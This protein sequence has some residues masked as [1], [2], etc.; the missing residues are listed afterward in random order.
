MFGSVPKQPMSKKYPDAYEKHRTKMAERSRSKSKESR[1]I[2]RSFPAVADKK[3][4]ARCGASFRLFCTTYFPQSFYLTFSEDHL[5]VIKRIEQ[6]VTKGGLFA[7]A[8]PRGSGKTALSLAASLWAVLYGQHE[9]VALVASTQTKAEQLLGDIW[10]HLQT[11][12]LLLADFPEV[13]FPIRCLEGIKQRRLLYGEHSIRMLFNKAEMHLPDIPGSPAASAIIRA[14]G[15][16]G[17]AIRGMRF[18]RPDGQEVRPSVV[19]IDDPQTDESAKSHSQVEERTLLLNGAVLGMAGPDKSMS[20]IMPCTVIAHDDLADRFLNRKKNPQWRGERTKLVYA[21][22][23][24]TDLWD[25]YY[26]IRAEDM[27]AERGPERCNRF[28]RSRRR[29]MDEGAKVGWRDR[30]NKDELSAI[31]HAMN[32][33]FDRGEIAFEAEYQNEPIK[34]IT[35]ETQKLT[36]DQ[37]ASRVN[38][39]P[40]GIVPTG[41]TTLTAFVDV[42]QDVLYWLVAAWKPDFTGSV[43]DYGS[44][45]DQATSYFALSKLRVKLSDTYPRRGIEGAWYAGIKDLTTHLALKEWS[46][47][48]CAVMR[49]SRILVDANDGNATDTV[50]QACRESPHAAVVMPS[51]GKGIGAAGRP[52][53]DWTIK[54]GDKRGLNLVIY[55][56]SAGRAIANVMWDVNWWKSFIFAR[57]ATPLGD[58]GAISLFGDSPERHRMFVEHMTSEHF[59][60]TSLKGTSREVDEWNR[61]PGRENHL[62]DCMVG[63]G[64]A[65]A[66]QGVERPDTRVVIPEKRQMVLP[67]NARLAT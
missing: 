9:F 15:L 4:R 64:V 47:D 25:E 26:E 17:S 29:E 50:F 14:A 60:R 33:R 21:W 22:P 19:V 37:I 62:L 5:R 20:G 42:Q 2:K 57:F 16:S 63:A 46:R 48:D 24:R 28:Y 30:K 8:M 61:I 39:I 31:Q 59:K 51:R 54:P 35:L 43:I 27:R 23:T 12:D 66:M 40:R 49:V 18:T 45:P 34:P 58:S 11:N 53:A 41:S 56:R 1:D 55:G 67:G 7:L 44:W 38:N 10:T 52:M 32:L 13:C 3:R 6:A 65:A 36:A